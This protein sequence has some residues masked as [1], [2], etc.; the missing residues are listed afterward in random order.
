MNKLFIGV[1]ALLTACA[2]GCSGGN[3]RTAGQGKRLV[4]HEI[5]DLDSVTAPNLTSGAGNFFLYDSLI[6][7]ADL[8]AANVTAY[9]ATTGDSVASFLRRGQGPKEI[10]SLDN[11]TPVFNSTEPMWIVFSREYDVYG[12]Y[13]ARDSLAKYG[14]FRL[15]RMESTEDEKAYENT[16]SYAMTGM[17]FTRIN[18]ST[19]A[20]GVTPLFQGARDMDADRHFASSHTMAAFNLN[21]TSID[22]LF[23]HLPEVYRKYPSTYFNDKSVAFTADSKRYFVNFVEDSLIQYMEYPDKLLFEFGFDAPGADREYSGKFVYGENEDIR[24]GL[25]EERAQKSFSTGLFYDTENEVLLRTVLLDGTSMRNVLQV[26]DKEGNLIA[27]REVPSDIKILGKHDGKYYGV[28]RRPYVDDEQ[29][30]FTFFS[31][32]LTPKA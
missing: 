24:S 14:R 17:E 20:V 23:G 31:F 4:T 7:F 12:F 9:S 30:L 11:V 28:R 27:E 10:M 16:R 22:T 25:R 5:S 32:T 19:L 8:Y 2:S 18:D 29:T 13:P 3:E 26:Y 21:T 15:E 6:C 1:V